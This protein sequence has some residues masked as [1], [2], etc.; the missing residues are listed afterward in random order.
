MHKRSILLLGL[1][2]GSPTLTVAQTPA[3]E[4]AVPYEAV[5][6]NLPTLP[7]IPAGLLVS[8]FT[9]SQSAGP[10]VAH[11]SSLSTDAY[12]HGES[13]SSLSPMIEVK[14]LF[15]TQSILPLVQL[16][17]G[18]LELDGFTSELYMQ[19]VELGPSAAGG[20]Q[21][22]RPVRQRY[23]CEPRSVDL[24]GLSLSFHFGRVGPMERPVQIWRR[25]AQLVH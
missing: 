3:P 20:L 14:T 12:E 2:L 7:T 13:L 6:P 23:P 15:R 16:W 24:S 4:F 9:P 5:S 11:F 19:N 22:F 21:D 1:F 25:L 17:R 10:Y 8:S 18:R